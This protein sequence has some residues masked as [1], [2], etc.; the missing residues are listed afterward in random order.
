MAEIFE[1]PVPTTSNVAALRRQFAGSAERLVETNGTT[2]STTTGSSRVPIK[3]PGIPSS[4]F[5]TRPGLITNQ[6]FANPRF[7]NRRS[8]SAG[9]ARVLNHQPINKIR[10]GTIMQPKYPKG[11]KHITQVEMRDLQ[12]CDEYVTTNQQ[13]DLHGKLTTDILKVIFFLNFNIVFF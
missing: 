4:N 5:S 2:K 1:S 7:H 10:T 9:N 13:F 3:R 12:N 8:R 11:T 6:G